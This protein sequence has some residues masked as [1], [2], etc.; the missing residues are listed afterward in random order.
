[1]TLHPSERQVEN[2]WEPVVREYKGGK[3]TI[4]YQLLDGEDGDPVEGAV[5][6][7]IAPHQGPNRAERRAMGIRHPLWMLQEQA[8]KMGMDGE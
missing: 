3:T 5:Y 2:Y 4:S 1:L 8:R 7:R 6:S